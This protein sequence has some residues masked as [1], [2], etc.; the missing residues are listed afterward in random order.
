[1]KTTKKKLVSLLC[2]L[3]SALMLLCA[4]SSSPEGNAG[5]NGSAAD[6]QPGGDSEQKIKDTL[7]VATYV[8]MSSLY[9]ANDTTI[10]AANFVKNVYETLLVLDADG[11]L[12]PCLAESWETVD[13]CTYRIRLKQGVKFHNGEEL[14]ASDVIFSFKK[15]EELGKVSRYVS[16]YDLDNWVAEDEYTILCKTKTPYGP[17]LKTLAVTALSIV[18]E[19]FVTENEGSLDTVACG[20]GPFQL[21]EWNLEESLIMERFDDYH[22]EKPL[23]ETLIFRVITEENSRLLE[24]ETGGV[25]IMMS[26]PG[27]SVERVRSTEGLILYECPGV[28]VTN[29][30]P[31][32][33][34]D[35][36]KD[37]NV[38]LAIA[39]AIDNEALTQAVKMDGAEAANN[40]YLANGLSDRVDFEGYG[41]DPEK[42]K[43]L[44]AEAGYPDGMDLK[45]AFYSS[46]D[47]RRVGEALQGMM[48]QAGI[49]LILE[50]K[51]GGAWIPYLDACEQELAIL[52]TS[53]LLNDP[54]VTIGKNHSSTVGPGGSDSNYAEPEMDQWLDEALVEMDPEK[55]SQMY[56]DIQQFFY[57]NVVLIPLF[58][59]KV[60][61]ASTDKVIGFELENMT[62]AQ[63]YAHCYALKD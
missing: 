17:F 22:G 33:Q 42:S 40:A 11:N 24:L 5:N 18:N 61:M 57:D 34:Q 58:T 25:D 14:T 10:P 26:V 32:Y 21:V 62:Q 56:K 28:A 45:L 30:C 27:V 13:D 53:N 19:K 50:E 7:T 44:L 1:M 2:V 46:T 37:P 51:E 23:Y 55:R 39:H 20:T 15:A 36:L 43:Q 59:E 16:V 54:S 48:S 60:L 63:C 4:C 12:A 6:D 41:Y 38:R 35:F 9:P 52:T 31:N 8:E 47:N 29:V 3:L 49:N